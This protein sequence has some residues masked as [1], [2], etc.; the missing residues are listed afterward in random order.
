[1]PRARWLFLALGVGLVALG[2][3]WFEPQALFIDK[4][5]SDPV[6]VVTA[7]EAEADAP[8]VDEPAPTTTAPPGPVELGGGDLVSLDHGTSGRVRILQL[9]DGSRFVRFEGLRT[10]NGPVLRVYLSNNPADGPESDFDETYVDLGG[11]QGN[12]GDQNYAI[13]ADVDPLDYASVVIWCDR[14]DSA[15]GAAD[16]VPS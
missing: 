14:F 2:V 16:L 3:Y 1:M 5:V 10:D 11:L 13:P 4:R 8:T 12:L 9:A 7:P 15:F 6:P